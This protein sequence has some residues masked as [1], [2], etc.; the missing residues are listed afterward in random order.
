MRSD[1]PRIPRRAM[2]PSDYFLTPIS[3]L[4][5]DFFPEEGNIPDHPRHR[6]LKCLRPLLPIFR[7]LHGGKVVCQIVHDNGNNGYC[8]SRN[9]SFVIGR[10]AEFYIYS[11][12]LIYARDALRRECRRCRRSCTWSVIGSWDKRWQSLIIVNNCARECTKS[13]KLCCTWNLRSL[14]LRW[15]FIKPR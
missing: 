7:V 2:C 4:I 14:R 15:N 12:A 3:C 11:C 6:S 9:R 1:R 13:Q 8:W 5:C 10:F